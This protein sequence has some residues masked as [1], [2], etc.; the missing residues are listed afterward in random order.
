MLHIA[1]FILACFIASFFRKRV[2]KR[3]PYWKQ[4]LKQGRDFDR[5]V[6]MSGLAGPLGWLGARVG[7]AISGQA[8]WRTNPLFW[9][10]IFEVI[11][12]CL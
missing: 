8:Y 10:L 4:K 6:L 1:F 2:T 7:R 5:V 9:F 3:D 12:Y 11:A